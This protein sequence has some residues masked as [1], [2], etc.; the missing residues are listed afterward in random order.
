MLVLFCMGDP[1]VYL[2]IGLGSSEA[3]THVHSQILAIFR[4]GER[5][6]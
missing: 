2:E 3:E 6:L 5:I 1:M 4:D